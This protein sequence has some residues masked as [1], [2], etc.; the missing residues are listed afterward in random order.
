M[1]GVSVIL[2]ALITIACIIFFPL[3]AIW[4]LN[5][6]FPVLTIPYTLKTW[7]AMLVV[8][9]LFKSNVSAKNS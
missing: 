2:I 1:N 8:A 9:G 7:F 6:L 5:V 3:L 4:A